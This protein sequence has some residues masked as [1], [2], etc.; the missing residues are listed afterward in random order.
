MPNCAETPCHVYPMPIQ[1]ISSS[2]GNDEILIIAASCNAEIAFP[3][4]I[5]ASANNK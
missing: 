1:S 3:F 5:N 2:I 4:K